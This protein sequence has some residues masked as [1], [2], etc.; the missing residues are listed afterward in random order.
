MAVMA[1]EGTH[2][3]N[4][5]VTV[6]GGAG[7]G[8]IEGGD[9]RGFLRR[10]LRTDD[11][12]VELTGPAAV[13]VRGTQTLVSVPN[14]LGYRLDRGGSRTIEGLSL[15]VLEPDED[16][17]R[18]VEHEWWEQGFLYPSP[19]WVPARAPTTT[20]PL[21]ARPDLPGPVQQEGPVI[22][23]GFGPVAVAMDGQAGLVVAAYEGGTWGFD[24]CTNTWTHRGSSA[25]VS[26]DPALA[27]V[28][29]PR[30]VYDASARLVIAI[31]SSDATVWTHSSK[32]GT[33]NRQP[34]TKPRPGPLCRN[35]SPVFDPQAGLVLVRDCSSVVWAYDVQANAWA[36]V[37][38]GE[39]GPGDEGQGLLAFDQVVDRLVLLSPGP[40]AGTWQLDPRTGEWVRGAAE[41]QPVG[42]GLFVPVNPPV[43]DEV[44]GR[45]VYL[46]PG[47]A[48]AAYD[49]A[50]DRWDV[51]WEPGQSPGPGP[52]PDASMV[53]DP[54]NQR[55]LLVAG[56]D[57]WA[58]EVGTATWTR[59]V[60]D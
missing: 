49:A 38:R 33:W 32:A 60:P 48:V 53:Y 6:G 54:V 39:E 13:T 50:L 25:P 59:L 36:V 14:R 19:R 26:A 30:L 11:F 20:C 45:T 57:V 12:F 28:D 34:A 3:A 4:G 43:F 1:R 18:V 9:L 29:Y 41:P 10:F 35:T 23:W 21:G 56:R 8:G 15:F 16:G 44:T 58:F 31:S 46:T 22:G 17:L 51:V 7:A 24:V 52:T 40:D 2:D 55:V 27:Q 5:A 47:G 37:D 42:D